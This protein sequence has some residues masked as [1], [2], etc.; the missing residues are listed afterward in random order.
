MVS[1]LDIDDTPV[2]GAMFPL[3]GVLLLRAASQMFFEPCGFLSSADVR[4]L[5][6]QQLIAAI[7]IALDG[8]VIDF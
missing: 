5:H 1:D 4:G 3:S 7:S 2:P 6:G 8:T